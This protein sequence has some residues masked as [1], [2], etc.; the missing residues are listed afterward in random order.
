M[1]GTVVYGASLLFRVFVPSPLAFLPRT[2]YQDVAPLSLLI[3]IL[4]HWF[5]KHAVTIILSLCELMLT[6]SLPWKG[7]EAEVES[8]GVG[9]R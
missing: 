6:G 4:I 1:P 5:V 9:G 2:A 7:E 8:T 3:P